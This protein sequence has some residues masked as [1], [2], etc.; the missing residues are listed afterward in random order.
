MLGLVI[1]LLLHLQKFLERA[2][3]CLQKELLE[4]LV[5]SAFC[6]HSSQ[7]LEA[8]EGTDEV[9]SL[10]VVQQMIAFFLGT[11]PR[12]LAYHQIHSH[13]SLLRINDAVFN[14]PKNMGRPRQPRI[15]CSWKIRPIE[16]SNLEGVA[17]LD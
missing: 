5:T 15:Y 12:S 8:A 6:V 1:V 3:E 2:V 17:K 4:F 7:E 10:L 13:L 14:R 9:M 16:L 11:H